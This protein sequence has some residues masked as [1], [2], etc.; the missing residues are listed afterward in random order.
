MYKTLIKN[1]AVPTVIEKPT[2]SN[3]LDNTLVI[4][5]LNVR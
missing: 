3:Y 2:T 5:H 4:I 1:V